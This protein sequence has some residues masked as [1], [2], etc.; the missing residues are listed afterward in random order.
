QLEAILRRYHDKQQHRPAA[1]DPR[2]LTHYLKHAQQQARTGYPIPIF[3]LP[4]LCQENRALLLN[5]G[6]F[7]AVY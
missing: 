1:P 3:Q 7:K 4:H 6:P 2:K 5:A